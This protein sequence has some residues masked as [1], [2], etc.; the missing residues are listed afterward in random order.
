MARVRTS[1]RTRLVLAAAAVSLTLAGPG[2]ASAV[3]PTASGTT[4][5]RY[6]VRYEARPGKAARGEVKRLGGKVRETLGLINGLA[7]ELTPGQLRRLRADP[8]VAAIEPDG[9]LVAFDHASNTGDHEYENAWGVEHIGSREVHLGG[10]TGQGIKLAI[11]DTGIDYIHDDPDDTPYVVDPEFLGNYAGGYD[12]FNG[13]ADPYD[14]NGHG[15]HVAGIAAAEHNGYLVTGVAPGVDL[16]AL[17]VLSAA[18][19][20]EYSGLIAALEWAVDND[21][22][23][24]NMSLGGHEVSDA[25][26]A[27]IASAYDAGLTLVAAS[28][29][30]V[31]FQEI[32][33]GCPVAYPAAYDQVIAVSFTNQQDRITGLSCTGPQMDFAAP[34]DG[35]YSPV[36]VGPAGSCMFC[37]PYGY[38]AQSGTSM[39]SP[40]VAGLAA[41]VLH[42]GIADGNGDGLV[43]DDLKAHLCANTSPGNMALTDPKYA[44]SFGCGVVDADKALVDNPPP[45]PGGGPV[46]TDDALTVPEDGSGAVVVLANDSDPD[47]ETLSILSTTDPA[48]GSASVQPDDTILY[49]PDPDHAGT[50]TFDYTIENESGRRA[51]GSVTV[52]ITPIND[53][54]VAANDSATTLI[55]SAAIIDVLANDS[56]VDGDTLAVSGVGTPADGTAVIEADG[57][58]TY[59]PEAGFSGADSFDYQISDGVGG[60][61]SAT[62]TVAVVAADGPPVAVD[63][64]ATTDEDTAVAVDVLA[65]DVDPEGGPLTVTAVTAP[66]S[67]AAAIA[68][69]GTVTYTPAADYHGT[70]TFEYTIRDAAGLTDTAT[71]SLDVTGVNDQPTA[72][73]DTAS[74]AEDSAT[75]IDVLANDGDVDGDPLSVSAVGAP[76]AGSVAVEAD[77][78]LTYT[79]AA[80]YSGSD[81]FS[82]T[83]S[84]GAS[85]TDSATV[86]I[87]V[88]AVND[89][90]TAADKTVTTAYGKAVAVTMT[91][92]DVETCNL[93]FQIVTP[94]GN[95]TLNSPSSIA[96]VGALPPYTDSSKV[97]YTP[98]AGFSGAD[99]FTYRVSDGA[100]WSAPA[101]VSITVSPAPRIHVGDIDQ[102]YLGRTTTWVAIATVRV[103]TEAEA[104]RSGVTVTGTWSDGAT[105]TGTCKTTTGGCQ[106]KL[107]GVPRTTTSVRFTVTGLTYSGHVYDPAV[108]H[109]PDGDSD[110]TTIVVLG[111][112]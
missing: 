108:N 55:D 110:G 72:T 61:A 1:R 48:H 36:P 63:D 38:S 74:T 68:G 15:T 7:V 107:D 37:T 86:S 102:S 4:T 3:E 18:G 70:D 106:V 103:H 23:V 10:N 96:C 89:P 59:T 75:T 54:P 73:D 43:A 8:A 27:A 42:A 78:R 50:D 77:G 87:T 24:V 6:I 62:V 9:K 71:V 81:S 41:L 58:I 49:T 31:T 32:L 67:G 97:T 100:A 95:G 65:N 91:G 84:D 53:D 16:Y 35:I 51:T 105:G 98:A 39:A 14:D 76:G 79:P 45:P 85:G 12:F 13:D 88:S 94:P 46:A 20:G 64:I 25:L 104:G 83:V 80:N 56:D 101:T 44:R 111:P 11:I 21:M 92:G 57:S 112:P 60:S 69:D 19:E 99:G 66:S 29:N 17:K 93:T 2:A 47:G 5:G 33:N 34:G 40:H 30:V 109:D 26:Q 82:Y 90:P 22:D 52:T 28:G